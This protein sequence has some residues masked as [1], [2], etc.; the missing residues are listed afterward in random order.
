M[1]RVKIIYWEHNNTQTPQ[2]KQEYYWGTI[3]LH[4]NN[5]VVN[6]EMMEDLP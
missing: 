5:N 4:A 6:P 1:T 3:N 2:I